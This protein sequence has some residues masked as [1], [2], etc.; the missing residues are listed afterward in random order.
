MSNAPVF[1]LTAP[2]SGSTLLRVMLAGHPGLFAPPELRLLEFKT[3]QEREVSLGPCNFGG[4]SKHTCDQ[5]HGLQRAF[6]ELLH[7]DENGSRRMIEEMLE[8]DQST[9]HAF[10]SLI[11]HAA[12]RRLVDK[13]PSYAA[14]LETLQRSSQLFPDA[15][16]I[17]LHRHPGAVIESI[18]RNGFESSA[19]KAEAT[20]TTRNANIQEFLSSLEPAQQIRVPYEELVAEPEAVLRGICWFLDI[21]FNVNVLTP[22][23]GARMTDGIR[24]GTLPPGDWNFM[25]HSRISRDR[26]EAWRNS[27][28]QFSLL[29]KT[30][31]IA[32][33]LDY[34]INATAAA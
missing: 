13:S 26:A 32:E 16:Y 4:C 2:R 20:W 5:R 9:L 24:P 25:N 7:L 17:Y 19:A 23:E 21:E 10:Q 28:L 14:R 11:D 6:M 31:Q 33:V 1:I 22:Y 3:M 30:A 29:E 12:P 27:G 8:R 18:V 15:Q 34:E